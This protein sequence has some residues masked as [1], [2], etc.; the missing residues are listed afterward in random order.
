MRLSGSNG[1]SV[2]PLR[3]QTV[4]SPDA[5]DSSPVDDYDRTFD[6]PLD[7]VF[8]LYGSYAWPGSK[9][10]DFAIGDILHLIGPDK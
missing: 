6:M 4:E 3:H 7:E 9:G 5:Y 10:L 2:F 1:S 8:K